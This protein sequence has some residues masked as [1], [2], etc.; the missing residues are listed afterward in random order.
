MSFAAILA[1]VFV[2][3]ALIYGLLLH[4]AIL[5]ARA[6]RRGAVVVQ[7]AAL[8]TSVWPPEA[9]QAGNCFDNQFQIPLLFFVLAGLEIVTW[10]ADF[11]F[12]VL[13]WVFVA[14]RLAHAFIHATSNRLPHRFAAF[15]TGAL[16]LLVL[17]V[18]FAVKIFTGL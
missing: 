4:L 7:D 1:P 18:H 3:V 17:W 5:R 6:V 11:V 14:S 15:L 16:I 13:S 9:L 10:Q 8:D 12:V 2:Q